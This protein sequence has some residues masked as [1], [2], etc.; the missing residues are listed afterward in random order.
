MS[1]KNWLKK[2]KSIVLV[3]EFL[4]KNYFRMLTLISPRLNT[5]MRYKRAFKRPLNL[6]NPTTLNEKNLKLKLE[7]YANDPLVKQCADKYA[8]REYIKK[9]GCEDILVKLIASYDRVDDIDFDALPNQFAMKWNFGCGFNI[10]CSDKSKLDIDE[11]KKKMKRWSR[12][13]Q[14]LDYSEMQYKGVNKKI[15]VEEYL[16]PKNGLLP[17]DYKVYCFRGEPKFILVC[18]GREFGGHPKYYFFDDKW[19]LAR[20]NRDSK[21]AP[22]G[23]TIEKPKCL[24]KLLDSARK[25]SEP[26]PFVRADFY[27]VND[28]VYFGELTFTPAGAL[29]S[30]R[31]PE[32]DLMMGNL[33]KI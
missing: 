1:V 28:K 10:I 15:I 26:F 16:K 27:I 5:K 33:L 4:L 3:Y 19:N 13:K 11:V 30:A 6:D 2:N 25:L 7:R 31:L 17:E 21:N 23:F 29:D 14:Y 9:K 24:D 20:I 32:T 18:V 22:E 12:S 8:V